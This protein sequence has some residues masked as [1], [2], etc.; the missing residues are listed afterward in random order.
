MMGRGKML[1]VLAGAI[2][3]LH[4]FLEGFVEECGEV[5][6]VRTNVTRFEKY[7]WKH[8]RPKGLN[9]KLCA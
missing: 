7:I 6:E 1:Q 3:L 9:R 4:Q 2:K 8:W 5:I